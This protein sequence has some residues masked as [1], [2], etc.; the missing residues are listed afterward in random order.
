M[1]KAEAAEELLRRRQAR[2][3]L[4]TWNRAI[5]NIPAKHHQLINRKLQEITESE[6]PRYII[7]LMPPG[8][9]KSTYASVAF[10]PWYLGKRPGCSILACSYSYTLAEN[11][12]RKARDLASLYET[13]LG[14][15]LK[16]DTKSAVNEKRGSKLERVGN[17]D[18]AGFTAGRRDRLGIFE[19]CFAVC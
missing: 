10:P 17:N 3:E 16:Q 8:A 11:F 4:D 12:G 2:R 7:I 1:T 15:N 6:T 13:T 18:L 19:L 9:A 5:G 14:Y